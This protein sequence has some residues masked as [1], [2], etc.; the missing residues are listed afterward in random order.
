MMGIN[1]IPTTIRTTTVVLWK[2]D[3][4]WKFIHHYKYTQIF[5]IW[6]H[7]ILFI[8]VPFMLVELPSEAQTDKIRLTERLVKGNGDGIA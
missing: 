5:L 7:F 3:S 6:S 1:K 2:E 8:F 4:L